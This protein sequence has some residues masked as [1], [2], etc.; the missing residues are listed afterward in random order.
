MS[1]QDT[2]VTIHPYFTVA[3]NNLDAFK[4]ITLQLIE[5]AKTEEG[6]LYY[7]FSYSGNTVFCREGYRNAE[8]LLAHLQNV[9]DLIE[10][11]LKISEMTRLEVHGNAAE[12]EKL[13]EPLA[14]MPVQFYTLESGFRN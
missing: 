2:A 4:A 9:G 1:S 3:E 10:Q 7:G 13:K 8:G 11:A 14:E 6:C 5:R 12:L